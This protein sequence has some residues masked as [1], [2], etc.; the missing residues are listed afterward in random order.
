M[1]RQY[2]PVEVNKIATLLYIT[3]QELKERKK[4]WEY[5]ILIFLS[6]MWFNLIV[7]NIKEAVT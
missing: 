3:I 1:F 2:L 7:T 4:W 6:Q 5:Y